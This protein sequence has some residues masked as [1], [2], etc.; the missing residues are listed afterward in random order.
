MSEKFS[1]VL[2]GIVMTLVVMLFVSMAYAATDTVV[3]SFDR[4]DG[5]APASFLIL[6]AAGNLYGTTAAGG[7]YGYGTVFELSPDGNGKW[8]EKVL[9]SF[10]PNNGQDG[11]RPEAGLIFD[12]A[13]NL[14]GTTYAGGTYGC[15]IGFELTPQAGGGWAEQLLH[16]FAGKGGDGCGPRAGLIFD[17]AG[18]LYGTT[19]RGGAHS[20][21]T[22]FE[23][24]PQA[25]GGW[26][27][28]VLY[29]FAGIGTGGATP[30]AGLI[31]D[32]SGNLYGTTW[33]GGSRN[34]GTV[35]ELTPQAG[36][37]WQEKALYSF[38][39]LEDGGRPLS[40]LT[41]DAAGN[42]YGTTSQGGT[43]FNQGTVFELTSAGNGKWTK[44]ILC[45]FGSF[46][47]SGDGSQPTAGLIFDSAG[48]LFGTTKFGGS[49]RYGAVFGMRRTAGGW[50]EG[51]LHSF[52]N[53]GTDGCQPQ[54]GLT[55]DTAGNLYGTT[56]CGG[57]HGHG[58]VFTLKR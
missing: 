4:I 56:L 37:G 52:N 29:S 17:A 13:G 55:L 27:E 11:S 32:P 5:G 54:A 19:A 48:N 9:Y 21:G 6:D 25:G 39:G 2:R 12:A 16:S 40:C 28:E 53:N 49:H 50:Q 51:R 20:F 10:D 22:V 18:N 58:T 57:T 33:A 41:L 8:T 15:G 46:G 31:F 44:S 45:S 24:M 1:I 7:A 3:Y 35:F 43:G 42:L 38:L 26:Q 34:V 36:G 14:Y 23:L 30:N 47:Q